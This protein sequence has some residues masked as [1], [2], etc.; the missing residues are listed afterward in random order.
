[1]D[2]DGLWMRQMNRSLVPQVS[3]WQALCFS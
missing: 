3:F 2:K 1:M